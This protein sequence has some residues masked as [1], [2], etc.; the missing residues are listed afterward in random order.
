[1]HTQEQNNQNLGM[2]GVAVAAG[3]LL[4]LSKKMTGK[5][6]SSS[7]SHHPSVLIMPTRFRG[8]GCNRCGSKTVSYRAADFTY[9]CARCWCWLPEANQ[10]NY[11]E[12]RG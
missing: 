5:M 12:L 2:I 9:M 1:M 10:Q 3:L 4:Y 8:P 7:S 11:I 6:L